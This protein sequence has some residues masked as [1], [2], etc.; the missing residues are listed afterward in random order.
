MRIS[1]E[2]SLRARRLGIDR[3]KRLATLALRELAPD[4]DPEYERD[5]AEAVAVC[6]C[7]EMA[8]VLLARSFIKCRRDAVEVT[9]V[10]VLGRLMK[11]VPEAIDMFDKWYEAQQN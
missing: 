7:L 2:E 5:F 9:L 4:E 6:A 3:A 1:R 11:E 8:K 10:D